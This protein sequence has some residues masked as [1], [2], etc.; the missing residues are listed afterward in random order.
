MKDVRTQKLIQK[1]EK[2]QE[3]EINLIASENIVSSDVL[4]A[5]GSCLG[6]KYAEGY[7]SKRYYKGNNVID[8]IERLTQERAL[9]LFGQNSG[10]FVVNVQPLSGSPANLAVYSALVPPGQKIMCLELSHG[11]H[12]SHGHKVSLTGQ[13]WRQITFG[14]NKKSER[15]DYEEIKKIAKK[16]RPA[17][18]VA[19]FTAYPRKISF[20]K[21]REVADEVGALLHVDMSHIAGLVAGGAHPSPFA[22][23]DVVMTTT[24]KTLRGPRGAMIFSRV[25]NRKLSEKIDKAVFPG[26]QGGPHINQIGALSVAL[27]EAKRSGFKKYIERVVKNAKVLAQELASH[28]FRLVSG[29]TDNHLILIDVWRD[30]KGLPGKEAADRLEREGII[31]NQNNIPYD[32]RTPFN[33]SGV[34]IGTAFETTKGAGEKDMKNIARRI[35]AVLQK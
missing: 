17:M 29:G 10:R 34:R 14:V 11:G 27:F 15:L 13:L 20:K 21:F 6:N 16:E 5:L 23:A 32:T 12:L 22:Y 7:P 24:H 8:E 2:R 30:G 25:D 19:G 28:G 9:S 18:I 26:I 3:K 4:K 35:A 31:V 33:P 1:E